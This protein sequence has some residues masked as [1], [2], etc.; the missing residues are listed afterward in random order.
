MINLIS[1]MSLDSWIKF[2]SP[3]LL[4]D[5]Y[6]LFFDGFLIYTNEDLKRRKLLKDILSYSNE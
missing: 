5:M 1:T 3:L 6:N 2:F 4:L